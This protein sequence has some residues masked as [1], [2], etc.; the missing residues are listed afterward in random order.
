MKSTI[1]DIR[2]LDK[3][4][5]ALTSFK[6]DIVIHMA[7]QPLVRESYI[8][9]INTYSTNVIGTA[10]LLEAS[11]K[12]PSIRAILNITTDKCY[13]NEELD[14]EYNEDDRLGGFDPYSN[15]KACSELVTSAYRSSFFS[16]LDISVATARAGNVIGG[17]DWSQDRL[18]PDILK[19]FTNNEKVLIRYPNAIRPWQHVLESISGYL[20]LVEKLYL[21]GHQYSESWNFGPNRQDAQSVEYIV[22]KMAE[23][24]GDGSSWEHDKSINPH[25]AGYLKL[26]IT[27]SKKLLSWHPKWNLDKA[28]EKVIMW[29]RKWLETSD[30]RS[31]CINQIKDYSN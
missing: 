23:F 14:K 9:P 24:W 19:S 25:E 13:E 6:P 11:R 30:A 22:N 29:H 28:L 27:K 18:L 20:K 15:S 3:L 4:S 7:A 16:D 10:N 31:I 12:C 5:K 1:G 2:D 21:D 8:D 17:G 26:D